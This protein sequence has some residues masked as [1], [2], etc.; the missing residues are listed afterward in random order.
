M[1]MKPTIE[2]LINSCN[3]FNIDE[4]RDV[5]SEMFIVA[6]KRIRDPN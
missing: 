4:L 2:S 5:P 3:S 1:N 6:R